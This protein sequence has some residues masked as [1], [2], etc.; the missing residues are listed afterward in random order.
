MAKPVF[1]DPVAFERA[2]ILHFIDDTALEAA[3][4][5]WREVS[6]GRGQVDSA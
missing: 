6:G 5:A 3:G 1:I 4:I 2:G